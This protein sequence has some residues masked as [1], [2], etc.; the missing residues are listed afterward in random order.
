MALQYTHCA[1]NAVGPN[2]R[3][4]TRPLVVHK[5][6]H[7]ALANKVLGQLVGRTDVDSEAAFIDLLKIGHRAMCFVVRGVMQFARYVRAELLLDGLHDFY[8]IQVEIMFHN[9]T[10]FFWGVTAADYSNFCHTDFP[11]CMWTY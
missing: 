7:L 9:L 6:G 10:E 8:R 11:S 2:F 1:L 3:T 5:R 4:V